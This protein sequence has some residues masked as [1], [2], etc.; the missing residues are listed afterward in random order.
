MA[1]SARLLVDRLV[2]VILNCTYN[3]YWR[4]ISPAAGAN[5]SEY[6]TCEIYMVSPM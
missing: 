1:A 4:G 3:I 5:Q 6:I 2:A